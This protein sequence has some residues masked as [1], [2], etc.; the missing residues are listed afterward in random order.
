MALQTLTTTMQANVLVTRDHRCCLADFGLAAVVESQAF[1][2]TSRRSQGTLRWMAP[3]YFQDSA[4]Q[5]TQP[6][7][8]IYAFSCTVLEVCTLKLVCHL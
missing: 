4:P 5:T 1:T 8:D 6:P 3:E 2:S 7:R